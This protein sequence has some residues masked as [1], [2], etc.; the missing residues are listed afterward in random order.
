MRRSLQEVVELVVFGLVALLIGTGLLWLVGWILSLGGLLLKAIAGLLWLLLRFV[1]PVAIVAGL[2]YFIVKALQDRES[3]KAGAAPAS[4]AQ[5]A[6]SAAPAKAPAPA[7]VTGAAMAGTAAAGTSAPAT[8]VATPPAASPASTEPAAAVDD[9]AE[10]P[11]A[12]APDASES[13]APEAASEP[14]DE[15]AEDDA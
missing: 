14:G 5:S 4:S 10:R 6:T 15:P 9:E 8:P 13:E 1:V 11:S 2:V 12:A 7:P 3:G